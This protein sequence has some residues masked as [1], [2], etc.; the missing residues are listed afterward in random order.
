MA[1][2]GDGQRCWVQHDQSGDTEPGVVI[3]GAAGGIG[4]ELVRRFLENSDTVIATDLKAEGLQKLTTSADQRSLFTVA[5]NL[6]DFNECEKLSEV[7]RTNVGRVD[8]LINCAG[9]FPIH[10]FEEISPEEWREIIDVNLTGPFLITRALLPLMK[11]RSWG[12][13]INFGSASVFEGLRDGVI[14]SRQKAE[15]SVFRGPLHVSSVNTESL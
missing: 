13:V 3:T 6:T 8:V 11:G 12:R 9:Y 4:A 7:V 10:S 5:A 1:T 15:L 2:I 14:T